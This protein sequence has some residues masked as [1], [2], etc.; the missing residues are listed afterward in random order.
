MRHA[1][2]AIALLIALGAATMFGGAARSQSVQEFEN[3][4]AGAWIVSPGSASD[5]KECK[6]VL[7]KETGQ[8]GHAIS[9]NECAGALAKAKAW[10]IAE[11]QLAIFDADG[12]VIAALG[13]NQ[14]HLTG[15]TSQQQPI[16]MRRPGA[17]SAQAATV[18]RP[19]PTTTTSQLAGAIA[20]EWVVRDPKQ[21]QGAPGCRLS[22]KLEGSPNHFTLENTGCSGELAGAIGWSIVQD[23]LALHDSKGENFVLLGGNQFQLSGKTRGGEDI[24]LVRARRAPIAPVAGG[25]CVYLGYGSACAGRSALAAPEIAKSGVASVFVLVKL[26]LRSAPSLRARTLRVISPNTCL[27]T[28]KCERTAEGLWCHA[29]VSGADGWIKK[30]VVRQQRWRAVAFA[31]GCPSGR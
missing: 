18:E 7:G 28:D 14:E 21:S 16:E 25:A 19:S 26:N 9:A 13:G 2:F 8:R 29:R 22:L 6:L 3:A 12:G 17:A 11:R 5:V 15:K 20:G 10:G 1:H 27:T 31:N 23:K 4:M 30:E 24:V